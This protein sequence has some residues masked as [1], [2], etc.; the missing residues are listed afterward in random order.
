MSKSQESFTAMTEVAPGASLMDLKRTTQR[1]STGSAAGNA[2]EE[3][4][5]SPF[6]DPLAIISVKGRPNLGFNPLKWIG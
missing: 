2:S 5:G 1:S 4:S 3:Q 6:N